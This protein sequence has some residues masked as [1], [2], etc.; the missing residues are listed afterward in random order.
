MDNIYNQEGEK[1]DLK[2]VK[3]FF[4]KVFK[5]PLDKNQKMWYNIY[6]IKRE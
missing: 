1:T 6:V 3:K 5:K 2:K 4:K